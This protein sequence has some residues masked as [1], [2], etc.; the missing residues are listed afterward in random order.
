MR[1]LKRC[2]CQTQQQSKKVKTP[3]SSTQKLQKTLKVDTRY[4]PVAN[5][6]SVFNEIDDSLGVSQPPS[7]E[8]LYVVP[9][10]ALS[11]SKLWILGR[12][13]YS[14]SNPYGHSALRYTTSDGKQYVMNIVGKPGCRMVN[15]LSPT[16]YLFG[17]PSVTCHLGSEQGGVFHRSIIGFRMENY[18]KD[19]I[20]KL[21]QYFIDLQER[22]IK[23]REVKFN[24]MA[25]P[26]WIRIPFITKAYERGNC[27][28]WTSKGMVQARIF[29]KA[30]IFP[31]YIFVKL[32]TI[33]IQ[34]YGWYGMYAVKKNQLLPRC[35]IVSY[36]QVIIDDDDDD[37]NKDKKPQPVG[38]TTP[39]L[40]TRSN[41]NFRNLKKFA[42]C[43]VD[44]VT[45]VQDDGDV[46]YK[47]KVEKC[48]PWMPGFLNIWEH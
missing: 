9:H 48:E 2:F 31:K 28:L 40:F 17:D 36:N 39:L 10:V 4:R 43:Q 6:N 15:F 5:I 34:S 37:N 45:D 42:H 23:K 7:I 26:G 30:T 33:A 41:R 3:I 44:L 22:E 20:D 19:R 29:K 32:Y 18:P 38:W 16:D 11:L 47:A 46:C 1:V 25:L 24:L 8:Y 14:S 21:H 13:V 35:N 12:G 27:A